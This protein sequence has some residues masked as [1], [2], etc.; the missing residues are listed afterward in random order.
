MFLDS[1]CECTAQGDYINGWGCVQWDDG[2]LQCC[3]ILGA[4]ELISW[5]D[6]AGKHILYKLLVDVFFDDVYSGPY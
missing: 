1:G 2:S 5:T 4:N 6:A 3:Q